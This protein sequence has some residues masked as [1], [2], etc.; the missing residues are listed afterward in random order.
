[1]PAFYAGQNSRRSQNETHERL[2]GNLGTKQ[3]LDDTICPMA[4][5]P[6]LQSSLRLCAPRGFSR[7]NLAQQQ[8]KYSIKPFILLLISR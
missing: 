3:Q 4:H 6:P 1:M 5:Y 2:R 8:V 7:L